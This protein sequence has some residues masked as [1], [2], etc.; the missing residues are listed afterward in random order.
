MIGQGAAIGDDETARSIGSLAKFVSANAGLGVG[1]EA[2][3]QKALEQ[4]GL[5]PGV[6]IG[7][8]LKIG[9]KWTAKDG[10]S[11][12]LRLDRTNTIELGSTPRDTVYLLVEQMQQV[13]RVS[14]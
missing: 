1:V 5:H 4:L 13:F 8:A 2:G 9:V 11:M 3:T 6:K 10:Y 12:E 7:H 14:A